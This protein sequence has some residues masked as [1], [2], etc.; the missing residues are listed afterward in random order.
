[1]DECMEGG[2]HEARSLTATLGHIR[3]ATIPEEPSSLLPASQLKR[4]ELP[5][6]E[7]PE[8]RYPLPDPSKFTEHERRYP[9]DKYGEEH[10]P[11]ARL[12]KIYRDRV[13]EKDEDLVN[14]WNDTINFMLVFAGLFSAVLTA[15]L[16]ESSKRLQP[17]YSKVTA[18][19]LLAILA[20]LQGAEHSSIDLPTAPFQPDNDARWI[21]GLWFTSLMLALIVSLLS[22]LVKQWLVQYMS[23]MRSS[24]EDAQHWAWRHSAL[25]RGL[26][27]WGVEPFISLLAVLLHISL[28]LFFIGLVRFIHPLDEIITTVI[29]VMSA[30]TAGFYLA[31]TIAPLIWTECPTRTPFT[32]QLD[33]PFAWLHYLAQQLFVVCW[34]TLLVIVA[35][36]LAPFA[37]FV[38]IIALCVRDGHSV[39]LR[40]L[41]KVFVSLWRGNSIRILT[42]FESRLTVGQRA[43]YRPSHS[44]DT[45]PRKPADRNRHCRWN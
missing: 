11:N 3:D 22:I 9:P 5:W 4:V 43:A 31:S 45:R 13:T 25:R 28:F 18:V 29:I 26:S 16:I 30:V 10:G 32:L 40:R 20:H 12:F 14:G 6:E 38:D 34:N 2:E 1:M 37:W 24:A 44:V 35:F 17:D 8:K 15:L 7:L 33:V 42:T 39:F 21:N 36:S 41:E 19:A 27:K 23:L